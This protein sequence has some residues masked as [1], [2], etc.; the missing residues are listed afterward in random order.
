M[1]IIS[2]ILGSRR[3]TVITVSPTESVNYAIQIMAEHEIGALLVVEVGKF[4][5]ILSERDYARK[6]VLKGRQSKETQVHEI[7]TERV[8]CATLQMSM[9][10]AMSIMTTNHIRHLPVLDELK[11][12]VGIVSMRDLV[13]ETIA[14]QTF[15][16]QQLEHYIA[17]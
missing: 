11:D 2:Q 14:E 13:Q 15:V 1:K 8:I 5:G 16:I 3:G 12:I 10:E 4:V 7:M 6:V 17:T 9:E